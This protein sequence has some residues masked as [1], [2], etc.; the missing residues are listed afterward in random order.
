MVYQ[1]R[2]KALSMKR[3]FV[4]GASG[5]V[6]RNLIRRLAMH[7]CQIRCLVRRSSSVRLLRK[8]GADLYLGSLTDPDGLRDAIA[9]CDCVFHLAGLTRAFCQ[10]ELMRVNA[11]GSACIAEACSQQSAPTVL[12]LVSS[13]AAAGPCPRGSIRNEADRPAPVSHYG[14]SKRAGE[15]AVERLAHR[16]PTTVI[17]PGVVFGPWDRLTLPAFQS[18]ARLGIHVVPTFAPPPLSMIYVEDLADLLVLAAERGARI[19]PA[20]P[21]ES[22]SSRTKGYYFACDAEYPDYAELGRMIGRAMGR[23]H[24]FAWHLADPF[25][26]LV[27]GVAEMVSR[28]RGRMDIV[29]VDK[30]REAHASSWASSPWA[31]QRDLG[32]FPACALEARIRDTAD[33]YRRHRWL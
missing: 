4:T 27:A 8:S 22:A 7:G 9:G 30:M 14:H 11:A 5:F 12:V 2:F 23:R 18:I 1:G 16:V 6:G 17:R 10:A 19:Q 13:V 26:W 31:A 3:V 21:S 29:N 28:L 24:V 32:F 20:E 25:P 15:L 33:W